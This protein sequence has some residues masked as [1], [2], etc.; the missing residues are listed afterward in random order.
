MQ[1]MTGEKLHDDRYILYIYTS[2]C[3][4]CLVARAMLDKIEALHDKDI[5]YSLNAN[6]YE[7]FMQSNKI[8]SVT[9]LLIKEDGEI[10]EKV[11]TFHSTG[12]IYQYLLKY[13]PELFTSSAE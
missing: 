13:K 2:F 9:C 8:E 12:N 5:F 4:T 10:K 6:Y 3:G 7:E 1:E 11:Y